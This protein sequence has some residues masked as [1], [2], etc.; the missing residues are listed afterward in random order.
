[1]GYMAGLGH[2]HHASTI[3]PPLQHHIRRMD[4]RWDG[5]AALP[6]VLPPSLSLKRAALSFFSPFFFYSLWDTL[7]TSTKNKIQNP[8]KSAVS[9][10]TLW[11]QDHPFSTKS[12][13][14]GFKPYWPLPPHH[15]QKSSMWWYA[16][17]NECVQRWEGEGK[18]R[19]RRRTESSWVEQ[20]SLI[21]E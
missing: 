20:L 13:W 1:M 14:L 8:R 12:P 9:Q 15:P 21:T 10:S 2:L 3:S 18:Q 11:M 16:C 4:Q 5:N 19:R 7:L 17:M 6:F